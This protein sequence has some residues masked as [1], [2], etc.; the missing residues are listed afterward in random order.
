MTYRLPK[1]YEDGRNRLAVAIVCLV[2]GQAAV[3]GL[4]AFATRKIFSALHSGLTDYAYAPYLILALSSMIYGAGGIGVSRLGERLGQSYAISFRKNFYGQLSRMS[5][6]DLQKKRLGALAIRFVGDLGAMREWASKGITGCVSAIIIAPA[7]LFVLWWFS[8]L[9][10]LTILTS[11]VFSLVAMALYCGRLRES[12]KVMRAERANLSI[13]MMERAG[14]APAIRNLG[15]I[16]RDQKLLSRRGANLSDVAQKRAG[17]HETLAAIPDVLLALGGV[18]LLFLTMKYQLPASNAAASMAVVSIVAISLRNLATVWDIFCAWTIAREKSQ[19]IFDAPTIEIANDNPP[20][21]KGP[22]GVE[23]NK[24][25][26]TDVSLSDSVVAPGGIAVFFGDQV[27]AT[28]GIDA[29]AR[30]ELL[31]RGVI[32]IGG[33]DILR[34]KQRDFSKRVGLISMRNPILQGSLRRAL[35]LSCRKRPTD[36]E[37]LRAARKFGLQEVIVRIGGLSGR[38][39]ENGKNLSDAERLSLHFAG[40]SLSSPSLVLIDAPSALLDAAAR[41]AAMDLVKSGSATIILTPRASGFAPPGQQL[42]MINIL[43]PGVD[44]PGTCETPHSIGA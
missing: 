23:L 36:D 10:G 41:T 16:R 11:I 38:I 17:Q 32:T 8:P 28:K 19:T 24:V 1:L 27:D 13:D 2:I 35:T 20:L 3:L 42:N 34:I 7:G 40:V 22:L 14:I 18:A 37:I 29:I 30:M 43:K 5:I 33:I 12:H 25:Q 21:L 26:F 4:G 44:K 9:Y 15:R 39:D 31:S 6:S